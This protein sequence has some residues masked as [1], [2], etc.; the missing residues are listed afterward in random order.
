MW[1]QYKSKTLTWMGDKT[2][3]RKQVVL[4]LQYCVRMKKKQATYNEYFNHYE[5]LN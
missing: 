5:W 1:G 4:F 3:A 2:N